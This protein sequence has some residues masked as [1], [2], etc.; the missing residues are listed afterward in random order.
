[1]EDYIARDDRPLDACLRDLAACDLYVGL[2]AWRYGYIPK[3]GNPEGR[4]ITELEYRAAASKRIPCLIYLLDPVAKWSVQW[5]DSHTGDGDSGKRIQALRDELKAEKLCSFF[6]NEDELARKVGNGVTLALASPPRAGGGLPKELSDTDRLHL[7][8]SYRQEILDK[9]VRA[10]REAAGSRLLEVDLGTGQSWWNTR[11]FLLAALAAEYTAAQRIV[12]F[13]SGGA[14]LGMAYPEKVRRELGR[15]FPLL[16]GTYRRT[17]ASIPAM[18]ASEEVAA[19]LERFGD[20][21][22]P[23]EQSVKVWV[24]PGL[25]VDWLGADLDREVLEIRGD[26]VSPLSLFRLIER[27]VPFIAVAAP[28]RPVQIIDRAELAIQLARS[29]LEEQLTR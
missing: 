3:E 29:R 25:L 19:I 26:E 16:E 11:L 7:G 27:A 8:T 21:L 10:I 23:D 13:G 6:K 22:L 18:P 28:N 20:S 1:M 4:S 15:Q 5:M 14:Y 9:V 12:F 24:E 2:F 17:Y